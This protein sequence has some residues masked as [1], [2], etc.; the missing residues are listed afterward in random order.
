M[1]EQAI[2]NLGSH[3]GIT[4]SRLWEMSLREFVSEVRRREGSRKILRDT[5]GMWT[6][7]VK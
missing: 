1:I 3:W 4:E 5:F 6:R 7:K 2:E